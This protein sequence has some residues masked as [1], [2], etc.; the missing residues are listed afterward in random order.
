L[1]VIKT[2]PERHVR[3]WEN[4]EYLRNELK[5]LGFNTGNSRTPI[6]PI[7]LRDD[8]VA[9]DF[10]RR[11]FERRVLVPPILFPAVPKNQSMLRIC[12]T[13]AYSRAFLLD[14]LNLFEEVGQGI[15]RAQE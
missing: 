1:D 10:S 5:P 12:V 3:L 14:V 2:E 9:L 11:L 8:K 7:M 15:R 13:A 4:T 6:I